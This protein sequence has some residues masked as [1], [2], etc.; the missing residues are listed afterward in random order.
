MSDTPIYPRLA[1]QLSLDDWHDML[2]FSTRYC[3]GRRTIAAA[4]RAQRLAKLWPI[5]PSATKRIIRRDLEREFERD[6]IA[7]QG[8]Q[9]LYHL[10]LGMDCDRAAWEQVRQAWIR[11]ESLA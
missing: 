7:R 11:E 1:E 10:P 4:Y 9:Q 2:I 8:D 5:L 3:L 6:D